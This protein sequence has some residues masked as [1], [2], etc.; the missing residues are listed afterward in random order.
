MST[1]GI[2]RKQ[3]E[4]S[5]SDRDH[6][7]HLG[8][9]IDEVNRHL[10][11]AAAILTAAAIILGVLFWADV[12]RA[13]DLNQLNKRAD[14]N[15]VQVGSGCSGTL[16]NVKARL[17]ITAYHCIPDA[18][19][20]SQEPKR[21]ED[22]EVILGPDGKPLMEPKKR[23]DQVQ[24]S[25]FF[26]DTDGKK[27]TIDYWAS[28]VAR[29]QQ[30]DV[31]ILRI[32]QKVGPLSLSVLASEDVPLAPAERVLQR[33]ETIW[34]IGNPLMLYGSV[35]KGIV[36]GARN[37]TDFGFPESAPKFFIQYDGGLTGGSS[38]GALYDD[39]GVYIGITTMV[40][41]KATFIGLAVGMADVW[42]VAADA[43]IGVELVGKNAP[44]CPNSTKTATP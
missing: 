3:Q 13:W 15:L 5:M 25:Q 14:E 42:K 1:R 7:D 23:V 32:P 21:D 6:L 30:L 38:G 20:T 11:R 10:A 34:H 2:N 43:C 35:T 4:P 37:L 27:G 9:L 28:I 39:T 29:N 24:V 12:A 22:G 44:K 17:I 26:W 41:P 19:G 40:V 36:S 16:V 31:A 33:G 18:I 8:D